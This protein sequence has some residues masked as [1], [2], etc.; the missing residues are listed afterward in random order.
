MRPGLLFLA[1]LALAACSPRVI[2]LRTTASLLDKGTAAFYE[3]SDPELAKEAMGSQLKLLEALL[4]NEPANPTL[5]ELTSQGFSGYAFLFIEDT[6]PDRARNF[7]L[8]GRDYGLRLAA[9]DSA[10]AGLDRLTL[11][12][13]EL[14]LARA[15]KDDV[16]GLFWTAYGWAGWINLS[17]DSPDAVAALPKVAA[18]MRRV[19]ELSPGYFHGGP[20]LF[21]GTYYSALPRM[22]GGDPAKS[23][24]YFESAMRE[25]GGH[26]QIANVLYARYYAVAVQDQDLFKRL[27]QEVLASQDAA[28][29]VRLAN[30]V[31]KLKAKSLLEKA[32]DLF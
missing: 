2:A 3:E 24:R 29:D 31:A 4:A 12:E 6:Q 19:E 17:K 22:L 13:L 25:E 27:N 15:T 14:R 9:R 16:P 28:P 1:T 26:F 11:S 30:A 8:R 18:I 23:K 5:L 10:F 21:L 20:D 32:N 7:Y